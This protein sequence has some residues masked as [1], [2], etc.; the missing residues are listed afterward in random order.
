MIE[1]PFAYFMIMHLWPSGVNTYINNYT[2]STSVQ[3]NIRDDTD[4]HTWTSGH[5]RSLWCPIIDCSYQQAG[6]CWK[7][8]VPMQF[9]AEAFRNC[10]HNQEIY[11]DLFS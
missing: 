4:C 5:H 11:I 1:W 6:C 2:L 10:R 9:S 7:E 3:V 8:E